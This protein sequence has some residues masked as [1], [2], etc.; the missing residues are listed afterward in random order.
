MMNQ[1]AR[2]IPSFWTPS[3]PPQPGH[4]VVQRGTGYPTL[5]PNPSQNTP[6]HRNAQA[7]ESFVRLVASNNP[8]PL[9][10]TLPQQDVRSFLPKLVPDQVTVQGGYPRQRPLL[11]PSRFVSCDQHIV[12]LRNLVN[13]RQL[14]RAPRAQNLLPPEESHYLSSFFQGRCCSLPQ[15]FQTEADSFA[16]NSFPSRS[17]QYGANCLFPGLDL[18]GGFHEPASLSACLLAP[19]PKTQYCTGC[20]CGLSGYVLRPPMGDTRNSHSLSACLHEK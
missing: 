16:Q 20:L 5:R 11:L 19:T 10:K 12:A 6:T 4:C 1:I 3:F 14:G 7:W 2:S 9:P 13:A 8:L 17:R 18:H 15:T